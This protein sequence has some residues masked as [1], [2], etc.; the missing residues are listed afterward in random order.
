MNLYPPRRTRRPAPMDPPP[1]PGLSAEAV[2][3]LDPATVSARLAEAE[4]RESA[5]SRHYVAGRLADRVAA[6]TPPVRPAPVPEPAWPANGR[7][8]P[9]PATGTQ[10][11]EVADAPSARKP[12]RGAVIPLGTPAVPTFTPDDLAALGRLL[13][14]APHRQGD[15]DQ[16]TRTT[17]RKG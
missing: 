10:S 3:A 8:A 16:T 5:A 4:A 13:A 6:S 9:R 11:S 7:Q 15:D 14:D 17:T 12:W 2:A 1:R